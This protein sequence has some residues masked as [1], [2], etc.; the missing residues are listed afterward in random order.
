MSDSSATNNS[1][2]DNSDETLISSPSP[3]AQTHSS[4]IPQEQTSSGQTK[5]NSPASSL[6]DVG[7]QLG[8]YKLVAKLGEGGMGAVYKARHLKLGRFVALKVLPPHVM[9]R[10]DA[11]SRF[12]REMLAVGSL[13]HP[14]IVHAN[15][16]GEFNG[17]HYLSMEYVEGQDLQVLVT[18]KGP[19][20]VVNACKAVRQA[21]QG[22]S[23][24]HKLGLVHRDIKPSN[25]FVAMQSGQ[26]KI[27]DMGLAL[28]SQEEIP[29]ALTSTGQCFGTPDYMAPEQWNDAHTCDA[30][31]DLYSLGCTLY[32]LLVGHPPYG[33]ETHRTAANKMKG[34]VIDPIPDLKSKRSD[35]PDGLVEIYRRLMSKQ[36]EERYSSAEELI[37]ALT[38]FAS[39]KG[40]ASQKTV[41]LSQSPEAEVAAGVLSTDP[42]KTDNDRADLPS[43]TTFAWTPAAIEKPVVAGRSHSRRSNRKPA[44]VFG[45]VAILVLLGVIVVTITNKDGKKKT[46]EVSKRAS[47]RV[48]VRKDG[49]V[50]IN[51]SETPVSPASVQ[52]TVETIESYLALNRRAAERALAIGGEAASV[53][54]RDA[55]LAEAYDIP[56]GKPLPDRP[57]LVWTWS[58]KDS[59]MATDDDLDVITGLRH[60]RNLGLLTMKRLDAGAISRIG[61]M[62]SP[63]KSLGIAHSNLKLSQLDRLK[64]MMQLDMF[65][66]TSEQVDDQWNSLHRFPN[67]R[68]LQLYGD[69]FPDLRPLGK[70]PGLRLITLNGG[71]KPDPSVIEE[72]QHKNPKL[73]I[74]YGDSPQLQILGNDPARDAVRQLIEAGVPILDEREQPLSVNDL[75][76]RVLLYYYC[77]QIP[78]T[79]KLSEQLLDQLTF[80]SFHNLLASGQS[81]ADALARALG[82]RHDLNN[83]DLTNSDLT[84]AGL[85]SLQS[86]KSLLGLNVSGSKVTQEAVTLFQRAAPAVSIASD[87]GV[88]LPDLLAIPADDPASDSTQTNLASVDTVVDVAV[89]RRILQNGGAVTVRVAD[90]FFTLHPG[91]PLPADQLTL[92]SLHVADASRVTEDDLTQ[93]GKLRSLIHAS[94]VNVSVDDAAI[95]PLG[96]L[97]SLKFLTLCGPKL[98]DQALKPFVTCS[99]LSDLMMPQTPQT[100]GLA[101]VVAQLTSLRE[102]KLHAAPAT[103]LSDYSQSSGFLNLRRLDVKTTP[104]TDDALISKLQEI[105]P[106]LQVVVDGQIRGNNVT[107]NAIETLRIKGLTLRGAIMNAGFGVVRE[108]AFDARTPT[109]DELIGITEIQIPPNCDLTTADWQLFERFPHLAILSSDRNPTTDQQL[110]TITNCDRIHS[111]RLVGPALTDDAIGSLARMPQLQYLEIREAKISRQAIDRLHRLLPNVLLITDFGEFRPEVSSNGTDGRVSLNMERAAAARMLAAGG[112]ITVQLLGMTAWDTKVIKPGEVLPRGTLVLK[113]VDVRH[114]AMVGDNA[115]RDLVGCRFIESLALGGSNVGPDS[116][117]A[118]LSFPMLRYL[119]LSQKMPTSALRGLSNLSSLSVVELDGAQVDDDFE[120]LKAAKSV[121]TIAIWG[122]STPDLMKLAELKQIRLIQF[123]DLKELD[124][125]L[126]SKFQEANPGCRI[127][128]DSGPN[129]RFVAANPIGKAASQLLDRKHHLDGMRS[130]DSKVERL[131]AD[132]ANDPPVTHVQSISFSSEVR[133][134]IEDIELLD[135]LSGDL[136]QC[137][138]DGQPH[139]DRIASVLANNSSLSAISFR[140]CELTDK[141]LSR[142]HVLTGLR[143]L[144]IDRTQVTPEGIR[145]FRQA[146]PGCLIISDSGIFDPQLNPE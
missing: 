58:I 145:A 87:V 88:L 135:Q 82:N 115:I 67:L 15:D 96:N 130:R 7:T 101:Q 143:S 119:H 112:V 59:T 17:I 111:L 128:V 146:V 109:T 71:A 18:T 25:L 107:K 8:P 29:A 40:S 20:S 97:A 103:F 81:N 44:I 66:V 113:N 21:A 75:S 114:M 116:A 27:L 95:K 138:V 52:P 10:Q 61:A 129:L 86:L 34:H 124:L 73:R 49:S 89:T 92:E 125:S 11:L 131:A 127:A 79:V 57:F 26:I 6:V 134:T 31:A 123:P 70:F 90:K 36:P 121:R 62:R 74:V 4:F 104:G 105:N 46:T 45:G 139:V 77:L 1:P 2:Q 12:E 72:I 14:N 3:E 47:L 69:P 102:L 63:L 118:I 94:L 126:V 16:A 132:K 19:M 48:D 22:L 117:A 120:F 39:S 13:H 60:V 108:A 50:E 65:W 33:S 91:D 55:N 122:T 64:P 30:R 136:Q 28:L 110:S 76:N 84:D 106:L 140:N 98:T 54:L 80:V 133:V 78:S 137:H 43:D 56:Q 141:D 24:A 51:R 85:R 32:F 35:V 68:V 38:P 83:L 100:E 23:A 142:L 9:S 41:Q 5:A 99:N 144:V 53:V 42:V 93:I 37:E